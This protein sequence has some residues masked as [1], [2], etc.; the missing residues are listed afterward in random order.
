MPQSRAS[1]AKAP[2]IKP[3]APIIPLAL[4]A[5]IAQP[6]MLP[7]SSRILKAAPSRVSAGMM[8]ALIAPSS[9]AFPAPI[10][11]C[12]RPAAVKATTWALMAS[13]LIKASLRAACPLSLLCM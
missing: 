13:S 4:P 8:A 5:P 12:C 9:Q 7:A 3:M 2:M 6:C 11:S 10:A 1:A